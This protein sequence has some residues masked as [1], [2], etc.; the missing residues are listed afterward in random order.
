MAENLT[1]TVWSSQT[2]Y[3]ST[4]FSSAGMVREL[5]AATP[6]PVPSA[7]VFQPL[8]TLPEIA[9]EEFAFL[10]AS[11]ERTFSERE[12]SLDVERY[13][14]SGEAPLWYLTAYEEESLSH[15]AYTDT[16]EDIFTASESCCSSPLASL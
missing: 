3:R 1:V 5:P 4:T 11:A 15:L 8:K 16:S 14:T 2:A 6:S 12:G 13:V 10:T 7:L 9:N